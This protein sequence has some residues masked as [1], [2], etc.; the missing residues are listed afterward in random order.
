MYYSTGG[1]EGP[2]RGERAMCNS[3]AFVYTSEKK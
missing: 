3:L 2:W 1:S